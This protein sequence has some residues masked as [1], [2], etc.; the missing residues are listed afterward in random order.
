MY[1]RQESP[2]AVDQNSQVEM[3]A[4]DMG[5]QGTKLPDWMRLL[6]KHFNVDVDGEWKMGHDSSSSN[7]SVQFDGTKAMKLSELRKIISAQLNE[8]KV[9]RGYIKLLRGERGPSFA[10]LGR[11]VASEWIQDVESS[12]TQLQNLEKKVVIDFAASRYNKLF[13]RLGNDYGLTNVEM[14]RMLDVRFQEFMMRL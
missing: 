7:E 5:Y 1:V 10:S 14:R 13:R 3:V 9:D 11:K 4:F 2:E 6:G 12:G 8:L